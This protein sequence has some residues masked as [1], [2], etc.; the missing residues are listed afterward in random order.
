MD[1]SK[2]P[3]AQ[4][5]DLDIAGMTCASCVS[6]IEKSLKNTPGVKTATVNLATEKAKVFFDDGATKL[7]LLNAVEKAGYKATEVKQSAPMDHAHHTDHMNHMNHDGELMGPNKALALKHLK[8]Q[9]IFSMV[10]SFPLILPMVAPFLG[11]DIQLPP[12]VQWALATPVQFWLGRRFYVA[13]WKALKHFSANMDLLVVLGTTAAYGLSLYLW[14]FRET[15]HEM[16]HL[17]F[18]GSA[19]IISLVLLGKYFELRA[20]QQTMEAITALQALRPEVARI[21]KNGVDQEHPIAHVQL[22]DLVVV[23][24]GEKIPVD[25]KIIEGRSDIDESLITGESWPVTKTIGDKVIG[26]S[27]NANGTLLIETTALGAETTLG[28]IVRLVENA[29]AGRAPIQRLADKVSQIFVPAVLVIALGTIVAWG[30][31]TGDWENAVINGVAVL[32]I[33]CPCALGLAT[34]TAIMVGT[35]VAAKAG[36]LIK[37]AEALEMAHGINVVAF[38][39]TGTLTEGVPEVIEFVV[40]AGLQNEI[41]K[42]AAAIQ[43]G[44][45]HPLARAVLR[46]AEKENIKFEPA[47]QVQAIPG[48]GLQGEV[49]G[50]TIA[51]GTERLM[52]KKQISLQDYAEAARRNETSGNTV[53]YIAD[54]SAGKILGFLSFGD[55]IKKAS[56][57]T[58]RSLH[59]LNIETVLITGDNEGSAQLV[60]KTLGIDSV[61]ARILPEEKA[62][63]IGELRANNKKV[64]MVGDG[65]ND[66]PAL[67]SADVGMAMST[68]TD[69]AMHTAGITLMR[70]NP[71]LIPE[72]IDISRRTYSKIKQNL[73]WAFIYNLIGIPLAAFGYLNPVIAGGAMAFSSVSVVA[74]S[75]LLK[76]WKSLSQE[77]ENQ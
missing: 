60:A 36:I 50:R 39:K 28:R 19:V 42:L 1:I 6:R 51:I 44:S 63:I 8:E 43:S 62:R 73:F 7:D 31:M 55:K 38:D 37:D 32:V 70:G 11:L 77:K 13:S 48:L 75:L 46:K 71:L 3:T 17:Y 15:H 66:A 21:R 10:L 57:K 67:A 4:E 68:G 45:E 23:F 72:A 41:L 27:V 34:P 76:R 53:S 35:G 26:G 40:E 14:L 33:A 24:P 69:V 12:W 22:K 52:Q 65:V 9:V 20:K 30:F 18:E 61:R 29:Q 47:T 59:E 5:I 2:T 54:M 64:A 25:G 49:D 74:N 58:I 16:N 56:F